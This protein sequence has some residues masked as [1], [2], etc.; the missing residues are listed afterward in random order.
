VQA[1]VTGVLGEESLEEMP[2]PVAGGGQGEGAA[3]IAVEAQEARPHLAPCLA[4]Q[5]LRLR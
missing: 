1:G 2:T 5:T 4:Q 3:S